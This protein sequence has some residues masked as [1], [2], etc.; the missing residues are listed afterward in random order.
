MTRRMAAIAGSP[1]QG[2]VLNSSV[3]YPYLYYWRDLVTGRARKR[4]VG[5]SPK[6]PVLYA[7]C[8][9]KPARFHSDDWLE[10]IQS[11]AGNWVVAF[12]GADH[13]LMR[14]PRLN[15]LV[16][17]WLDGRNSHSSA[18]KIMTGDSHV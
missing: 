5:Y 6:V 2:D 12:A 9:D 7:Y 10:L 16:R 14:S 8:E 4:F 15:G 13:W 1:R 18:T 11:R 3:N 17:D